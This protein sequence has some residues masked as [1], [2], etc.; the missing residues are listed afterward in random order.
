MAALFKEVS[1]QIHCVV[2]NAC[3]SEAQAKAIANHIPFVIGMNQAIGDKAAIA[4]AVGFYKALGAN[5]S[6]EKAYRFGC[7]EI[8]LQDIPE[9]LTP[10]LL[11]KKKS[12]AT[13]SIVLEA[14][15]LNDEQKE[16]ILKLLSKITKDATLKLR[17]IEVGS[18]K[19]V[20]EGSQEGFERI[21]SLFRNGE[22]NN[23][24]GI[25]VR[26][27]YYEY[28]NTTDSI[29]LTIN[30]Q[31]AALDAEELEAETSKLL[32]EMRELDEVDRVERVK[33]SNSPRGTKS[34]EGFLSGILEAKV[35][36][37]NFKNLLGY[38][39]DRLGSTP[40]ELEVEAKGRKFKVKASSQQ[41][42]SDAIKAAQ[43]FISNE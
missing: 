24:L 20:L 34:I 8:Q 15:G 42:L 12:Q 11:C 43:A 40:L 37:Q 19:L 18:I 9:N 29:Q 21:I 16:E 35:S 17:R 33:V 39:G 4:F 28:Q 13:W 27:V 3:Y 7:V 22:L 5:Y 41:E 6:V 32:R 10:V 2:L 26:N 14:D 1:E 30:L 31:D 36:F 23:I 25:S 38:L